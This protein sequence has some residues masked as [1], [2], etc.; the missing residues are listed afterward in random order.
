MNHSSRFFRG[1]LMF[2][3]MTTVPALTGCKRQPPPRP[4]DTIVV[5]VLSDIQS[6]NPYLC[7]TKFSEDLLALVY[8]S[9]MIENVDYRQHPPSFLSSLA[10]SWEFSPDRLLLDFHLQPDARWSDGKPLDSRDVV[11]SW[12]V[13]RNPEVG[14]Y[15]SYT[16][17]FIVSVKALDEH[18][19]RFRFDHSYPYELMDANEGLIIPEH[20]WKNIPFKRWASTSW[21]T[22]VVAGGPYM[23]ESHLPQQEIH[24]KRNEMYSI[25]SRAKTSR[26]V[27]RIVPEQTGLLSLLRAGELDFINTVPPENAQTIRSDPRY[28]LVD[29]PDRGYTHICWNMRK[30]LFGDRAVRLALAE[31]IDRRKIIATVYHGY[32]TPSYGPILS[33]MWAFDHSLKAVGYAPDKA[34][35]LLESR[36]WRDSDGDGIL[37]RNGHTFEFELLSNAENRMRQDI[38]LL[39]AEDL[40]AIGIRAIPRSLEW[41]SF[42]KKLQT[43]NFD[44]AVNRW[45]EPTQIDLEDL[46]HSHPEDE[47]SSNYGGYSNPEVDHLI[48]QASTESDFKKQAPLYHRIQQ[49]IVRDQPYVFLVESRRLNAI[50]RRISGAILND[51]TPYFNLEAW[52]LKTEAD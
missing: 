26:V 37:D 7:E 27:W 33:T 48:D 16:K 46:W 4:S 12:E 25:G 38:S 29:Y 39:V 17:D 14:W 52:S 13:Q 34:R 19:V 36:G 35:K 1:L 47:A 44:A 49:L 23:P 32:A 8:P 15:G 21:F 9:L 28:R 6:W 45:I 43:G 31:A 30:E 2:L 5:G 24:L 51:A 11:F 20:V 50:H 40:R 3:L 41:G 42:L 10:R 22:Q 18:T